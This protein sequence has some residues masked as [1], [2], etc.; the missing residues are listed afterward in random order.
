M[1]F[2]ECFHD[3]TGMVCFTF[4]FLF[5]PQFLCCGTLVGPSLKAGAKTGKDNVFK[6]VSHIIFSLDLM[7]VLHFSLC[8]TSIF[9]FHQKNAI[10]EYK[11]P[12]QN[13]W[14]INFC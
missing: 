10:K 12:L 3:V 14:E 7:N 5:F 13:P 1:F 2:C 8:H 9:T 6:I 11:M 4:T